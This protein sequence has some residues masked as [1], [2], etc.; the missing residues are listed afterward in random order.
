[1]EMKTRSIIIEL[2]VEKNYEMGVNNK[3]KNKKQKTLEL[4]FYLQSL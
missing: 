4:Q 1:M 2:E 3:T